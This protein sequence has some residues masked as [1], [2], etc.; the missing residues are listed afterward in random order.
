M[1]IDVKLEYKYNVKDFGA[2]GDGET[3]D[4][5]AIQQ[6]LDSASKDGG[7]VYFPQGTY[8]TG[9]LYL[10]S[11]LSVIM[12][13]KATILASPEI[14][15]Y[16]ADTHFNRYAGEHFLDKCL[17]YAEDCANIRLYGGTINGN[18]SEFYEDGKPDIIHP[19]LFRFLRCINIWMEDVNITMPAGWSTAFIECEDIHIRGIDISSRH[20]N[21]D[22]L[23]FDSCRNVF[24]SDCNMDTSDDCLCIQNSVAGRVSRNIIV[25]NCVMKS[26]WA[27]VRIGL[28]NSGD[29]EDVVISDCI[30]H[31]TLCSGFKIQA[32]ESGRIHDVLMSNIIMRNVTRPIFVTS[33]F[34]KMGVLEESARDSSKGIDGLYFK[35]II[36]DNTSQEKAG[37]M[38]GIFVVG[39]PERKIR[40][41]SLTEIRYRVLGGGGYTKK[42]VPELTGKRPE[43]YVLEVSPSSVLYARHVVRLEVNRFF[44][45]LKQDDLREPIIYEDVEMAGEQDAYATTVSE[46]M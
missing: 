8:L 21:G 37:S 45:D 11:D 10:K 15:Y 32:A 30:F 17:I 4:T 5:S 40:D 14:D 7:T 12:N 35:N 39:T 1:G 28:L 22:G 36:I 23:D 34:C 43:Y 42:E 19:M 44:Y 31:D 9:T 18:G 2:L 38:D 41:V 16:G 25:R 33:N 13:G 27:A 6:A 20:F 3:Y 24:V 46:E 26:K 29:I